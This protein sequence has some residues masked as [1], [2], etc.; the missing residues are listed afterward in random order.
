[1]TAEVVV[2]NRTAIAMAADS[3][4]TIGPSAGAKIYNTASKLFALSKYHPVAIM[5]YGSAVLMHVPWETLIKV[6]RARLGKRRF[7]SLEEHAEDFIGFIKSTKA[8]SSAELQAS[9]AK[10]T[11][12]QVFMSIK[13]EVDKEV[14]QAIDS[15]GKATVTQVQQLAESRIAAHH[16]TWSSRP[17]LQTLPPTHGAHLAALY[18][19]LIG[20]A[21]QEVF[22]QLPLG[23]TAIR[24]LDDIALAIFTRDRFPVNYSGVVIAG[25]GEQ[26]IFPSFREYAL[27]LIAGDGLK[28]KISRTVSVNADNNAGVHAFAQKDT[29]INFI[30]GIDP[31]VSAVLYSYL[32]EL[33]AAYPERI[34]AAIQGVSGAEKQRILTTMQQAGVQSLAEFKSKMDAH[35]RMRNIGPIIGAVANLPKDE[36]AEMAESLVNLTSFKQRMSMQQETVGG[37]IDVA[38][39]S[40]GDGLVWIKR[41]HYFD[42]RLNP[43]FFANYFRESDTQREGAS[44][45]DDTQ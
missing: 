12:V 35:K 14:S 5:N 38:V 40:K 23:P 29:V 34:I 27:D 18:P 16:A 33:F 4:V 26:D 8:F 24:Q 36:L 37:P 32:Q 22:Q 25:F 3:A 13:E 43:A 20:D 11:V 28:Y 1:M 39:I 31:N 45:D 21:R 7:D 30:E 2:M 19:A 6:Y 41:K 10:S 44:V 15:G 9:L 42:A 17:L